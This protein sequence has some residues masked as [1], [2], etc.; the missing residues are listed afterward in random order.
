MKAGLK[1]HGLIDKRDYTVIEA[2]FPTMPA[3]LNEKKADLVT[4][5]MPFALNPMLNQIGAP[6]YDQ[7]EGLGASQ[8]TIWT[9]RQSY[10]DKHRAALIDFME[11]MLRIERWYLDPKN[12]AEVAKIAGDLLKVPPE[13]LDWLFTNKD[14]YRDPDM[15]PDLVALQRNVD[16]TAEMGF[17]K[18]SF[19]V[20][21]HSDLSLIEEAAKRL[22]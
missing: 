2:P 21:Q 17:I 6:L 20:K 16:T 3:M 10:I 18:S 8:F 5:V 19:N 11:D 1:K 12:R 14:Y 13:R 15:M 4:G 7:T 9:A 22:K